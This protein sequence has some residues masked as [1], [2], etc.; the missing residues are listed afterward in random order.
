MSQLASE[1]R[2]LRLASPFSGDKDLVFCS[3]NGKTIG[4]R[5][6]SARGL[7][8]AAGGIRRAARRLMRG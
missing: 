2:R 4:H 1:L 8:K 7:E 5:N 3:A 6:L